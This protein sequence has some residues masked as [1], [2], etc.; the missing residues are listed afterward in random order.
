[1]QDEIL[2]GNNWMELKK[3]DGWFTFAHNTHGDGV[4]VLGY[5]HTT[6][7]LQYLLRVEHTPPHGPGFRRT[8][9]TGTI[10]HGLTPLQTAVK[11]LLEESGYTAAESEMRPYGWVHP[12]KFS[13]YKQYIYA[14]CLDG[15]I[16]GPI[17]G[18]GSDG[19]KGASVVWVPLHEALAVNDP[20]VAATIA[21]QSFN[22][23][24]P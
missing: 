7:G 24:T 22:T 18:D 21:Y 15:K 2:F 5:R 19:E 11:E 23:R 10:E 12:S 14:V 17:E 6:D 20:S 1:M 8:S 4:A 3:R 16:Q 9:L 13:D